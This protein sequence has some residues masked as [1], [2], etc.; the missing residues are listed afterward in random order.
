M[1]SRKTCAIN[2]TLYVL[3]FTASGDLELKI[4][5]RPA[6]RNVHINFFMPFCFKVRNFYETD[7]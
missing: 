1:T 5:T 3:N 2:S 6:L 4:G 7:W